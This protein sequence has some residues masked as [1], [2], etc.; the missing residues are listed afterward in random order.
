MYSLKGD[1]AAAKMYK[2]KASMQEK[3][4]GESALKRK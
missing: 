1:A 2:E 4:A 3:K